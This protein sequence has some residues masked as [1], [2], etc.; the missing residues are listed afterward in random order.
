MYHISRGITILKTT[1]KGSCLT[2]TA[3]GK[4]ALFVGF[5]KRKDLLDT[6]N[7]CDV[8]QSD[9]LGDLAAV[10]PNSALTAISG[11]GEVDGSI[12]VPVVLGFVAQSLGCGV[13]ICFLAHSAIQSLVGDRIFCVIPY[14]EELVDLLD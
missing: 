13:A 1:E 8:D 11:Q 12:A 3:P 7:I 6:V 14:E 10:D 5:H 9:I 4:Y 2:E